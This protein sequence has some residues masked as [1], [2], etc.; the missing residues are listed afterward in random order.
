MPL[1]IQVSVVLYAVVLEIDGS[2]SIAVGIYIATTCSIKYRNRV[3]S[4][5][6]DSGIHNLTEL[7]MVEPGTVPT[8]KNRM[9]A[10]G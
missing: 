4:A 5:H 7:V 9:F 1:G 6:I 10:C 2:E 8:R 3:T